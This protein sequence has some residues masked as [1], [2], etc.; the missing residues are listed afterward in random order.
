MAMY[1][2]HPYF[3][4]SILGPECASYTRVDAVST[5]TL[6]ITHSTF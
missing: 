5:C 2:T 6:E 1:K 3:W 4:Y